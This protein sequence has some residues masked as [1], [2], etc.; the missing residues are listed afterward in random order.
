MAWGCY[1][2]GVITFREEG[3]K[4]YVDS[5]WPQRVEIDESVLQANKEYLVVNGSV[6]TICVANGFASYRKI[7]QNDHSW[8]CEKGESEF[9]A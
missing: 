2:M 9:I 3:D 4:V 6:I 1:L 8:T 7:H 5:N